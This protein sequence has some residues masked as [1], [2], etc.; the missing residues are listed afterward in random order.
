M[1][2]PAGELT[3]PELVEAVP[4]LL[5]S[6]YGGVRSGRIR[7]LPDAR[8]V[9]WYQTLGMVD[10]PAAF[11]GRTALYG[12]R[13]LLQLAA[14]KKLQSSGLSLSDIQRGLAGRNDADLARS[15]GVTRKD[16]DLTVERVVLARSKTVV[17]SL[18][19]AEAGE[20]H[21]QRRRDTAFW[22]AAPAAAAT[23]AS[24][25]ST[26]VGM[27]SAGLGG[28]GMLLWNGRALTAAERATLARLS[29]PLIAFLQSV[30]PSA[31][32]VAVDDASGTACHPSRP[33]KGARP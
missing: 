5:A 16:V 24:V 19:A 18:A 21:S 28:G 33:E 7:D 30:Q 31:P 11:R 10:R 15:A 20:A 22:K 3:L 6:G 14:I 17:R 27:Q 23:P 25:P 29:E 1:N 26:A 9:R 4:T 32:S 12:S 8:T 13:H 2:R